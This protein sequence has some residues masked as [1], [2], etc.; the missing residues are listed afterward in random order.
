MP[1]ESDLVLYGTDGCHLCEEAGELLAGL[2]VVA[3]AVDI[4]GDDHLLQRYGLRIP[5]LRDGA[6]RELDWP[7]D[8]AAARRFLGHD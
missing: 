5:V 3:T 2:G 8:A 4:L 7:F 6:G 1:I